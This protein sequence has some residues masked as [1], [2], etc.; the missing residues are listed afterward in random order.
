[1]HLRINYFSHPCG[2]RVCVSCRCVYAC[3]CSFSPLQTETT[4][5]QI[6]IKANNFLHLQA[7]SLFQEEELVN[8]SH[9][10]KAQFI[11]FWQS[12]YEYPSNGI[13]PLYCFSK[14]QS[15]MPVITCPIPLN[16][17]RVGESQ[18][19]NK[20]N[21]VSMRCFMAI[22][23][24]FKF[25]LKCSCKKVD[26]LHLYH[27]SFFCK[28]KAICIKLSITLFR[29]NILHCI[30]TCA[31]CATRVQTHVSH[32]Q[33]TGVRRIQSICRTSEVKFNTF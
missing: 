32:T 21:T 25:K 33:Y 9:P 31:L 24:G 5:R 8:R 14:A 11:S 22:P 2:A 18:K 10:R 7:D 12:V 16:L 28:E 4:E 26:T 27:L 15:Q 17:L 1:M 30:I 6:S 13:L 29:E 20:L 19:A 23:Q 3:V